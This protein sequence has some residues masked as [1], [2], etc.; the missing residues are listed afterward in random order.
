MC[1]R[2]ASKDSTTDGSANVTCFNV[3]LDFLKL[4]G[5]NAPSDYNSDG[6]MCDAC[7]CI[8]DAIEQDGAVNFLNFHRGGRGGRDHPEDPK[9]MCQLYRDGIAT[10]Y[11]YYVA[12]PEVLSNDRRVAMSLPWV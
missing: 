9:Y 3:N 12:H 6:Y 1:A 8:R 7:K 5:Y 11:T 10:L 2:D 4:H